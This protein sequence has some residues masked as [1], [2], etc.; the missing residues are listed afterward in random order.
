MPRLLLYAGE[1]GRQ[2][3]TQIDRKTRWHSFLREYW[4]ESHRKSIRS[5][6]DISTVVF[7][8]IF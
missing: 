5:L 2:R 4:R 7:G 3:E 6:I 8:V 1:Q